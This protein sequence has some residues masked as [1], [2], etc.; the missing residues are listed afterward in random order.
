MSD[1]NRVVSTLSDNLYQFNSS[2]TEKYSLFSFQNDKQ[3]PILTPSDSF[4]KKVIKPPR[5]SNTI[6]GMIS[7]FPNLINQNNLL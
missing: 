6:I 2:E 5:V 3:L 4:G 7:D 1:I